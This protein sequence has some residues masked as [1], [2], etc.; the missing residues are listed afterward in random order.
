[1]LSEWN[2][3]EVTGEIKQLGCGQLGGESGQGFPVGLWL[4]FASYN[5]TSWTKQDSCLKSFSRRHLDFFFWFSR[6][7]T[8]Q[9]KD[10]FRKTVIHHLITKNLFQLGL[11]LMLQ[12][13]KKLN[14]ANTGL[15]FMLK[16]PSFVLTG[17]NFLQ[18]F[19]EQSHPASW[20]HQF[21]SPRSSV[22]IVG[23]QY[24]E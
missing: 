13:V 16:S 12:T 11:I 8:S 6:G 17:G 10:F 23:K 15:N 24:K 1:M 20:Q 18:Q 3:G 4:Q 21:L 22:L 9:P 14:W 5:L 7:F 2:V 19:S